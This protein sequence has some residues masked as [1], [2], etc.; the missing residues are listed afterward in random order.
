MAIVISNDKSY[1]EIAEKIKRVLGF[2]NGYKPSEMA[3]AI[4]S[5]QDAIST[6]NNI[7]N[8]AA[9][10][11]DSAKIL[12]TTMLPSMFAYSD[13]KTCEIPTYIT[14]ISYGAFHDSKIQNI[15]L[16][17]NVNVIGER[18]FDSCKNLMSINFPSGL[19]TIGTEAFADSSISGNIVIPESVT[20]IGDYAFSNADN[21]NFLELPSTISA[22]PKGVCVECSNLHH[23]VLRNSTSVVSSQ[24][25]PCTA[26][27]YTPI[28]DGTGYIYV[29]SALMNNYKTSVTYWAKYADQFRALEDYTVDGTVTG[30]FDF[31]KI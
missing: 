20:S 8:G 23:L 9:F 10:T 18:S 4:T 21:I 30:E 31:S 13:I 27:D 26:F 29:P 19:N 5:M 28:A 7:T 3:S 17:D 25:D 24:Y 1:K 2:D 14:E 15:I 22:I 6:Y 16:H 12:G 11:G